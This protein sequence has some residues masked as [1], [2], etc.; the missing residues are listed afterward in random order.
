MG[1]YTGTAVQAAQAHYGARPSPPGI[2]AD[3]LHPDP[4][5]DPFNPVPATPPDQSA[6]VWISDGY[7][8]SAAG[9]SNMPNLAQIPVSHWYP[10]Q[11]AV[12][13]G[14]P[15]ARAQQAMQERMMVDHGDTNYIPD[16]IRLYQHFSEGQINDWIIGRPP[17][18]A[19]QTIPEGPLAG[20]QYGRVSYD[21]VNQPTEVYSG[22]APN[23]GRYRLGVKS[24]MWGLYESPIGKFGQEG[25]LRAYTGLYPAFPFDKPPMQATAPYTPNSTG[26]THWQPAKPAQSPS[27][28][29]VPSETALTDYAVASTGGDAQSEFVDR[30]GGYF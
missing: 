5:P 29:A 6:T 15:Y 11:P 7:D 14:E 13:S 19:G 21:A 17:V 8:E 9:Q 3:H 18:A 25:M 10:G 2:N 20:L 4:E 26:T 28:F 30:N 1:P 12:P 16:S 22:D 27:L 23:V 24:N